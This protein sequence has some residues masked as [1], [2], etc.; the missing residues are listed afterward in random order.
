MKLV[1]QPKGSNLCGQAVVAMLTGVTLDEAVKSM[2]T[3]G[4]T[5]TRQLIDALSGT[6]IV[7][8]ERLHR[9]HLAH[10]TL[11]RNA[12]LK[13]HWKGRYKSHWV[14]LCD[15]QIFDPEYGVTPAGWWTGWKRV[16]SFLSLKT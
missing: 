13:M 9:F 14:L 7:P 5:R 3:R 12:I 6:G 2:H 10:A 11:L 15:D 1:R 16:S 8:S 4:T